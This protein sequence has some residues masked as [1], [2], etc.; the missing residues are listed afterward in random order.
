MIQAEI[1]AGR[2]RAPADAELLADA[3]VTVGERFPHHG[4]DPDVVPDAASAE[5]TIG[6]LL[7]EAP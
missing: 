4:G 5:R 7:R 6:L 2:Y 1:V 3:I